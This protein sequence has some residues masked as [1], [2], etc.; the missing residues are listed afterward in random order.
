MITPVRYTAVLVD[1]ALVHCMFVYTRRQVVREVG[2][3]VKI[4]ISSQGPISFNVKAVKKNL[5]FV[6]RYD[7]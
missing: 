7:T 1:Q 4:Y 5:Q 6:R 3:K 2:G